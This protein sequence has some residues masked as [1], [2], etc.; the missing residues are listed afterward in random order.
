MESSS[1]AGAGHPWIASD[2]ASQKL[3]SIVEKVKDTGSTLLIQGESGTG[4]DLLA[5]TLHHLSKRCAEPFLKIDCSCIPSELIE[6]ELFGYSK[7]AF[8]GAY[9]DKPGKLESAGQG[10]VVLDEISSLGLD[11]QAKLLRVIEERIFERL[12]SHDRIEINARIIALSKEDLNELVKARRFRE[13]LFFRI[14]VIPIQIPPLRDRPGDIK[15]LAMHFLRSI[16]NRFAKPDLFLSSDTLT[17]LEKYSF[18]GNVRELRNLLERAVMLAEAE[19]RPSNFPDSVRY[20]AQSVFPASLQLQKPSLAEIEKRY[21]IEILDYTRGNKGKAAKILGIS[22]KTL[23]EK[24]KR[25]G[26]IH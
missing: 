20:S 9:K 3:Q 7:G 4:K 14:N 17:C 2:P 21:I 5:L 25:Y 24:R 8:T 26:L 11:V 10:T 23:L 6:S 13:D 16:T 18:P 19:I 12:G 15:P 1:I 22:R